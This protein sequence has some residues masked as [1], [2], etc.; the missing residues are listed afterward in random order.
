MPT[1]DI[2]CHPGLKT[3]IFNSDF[4]DDHP[5]FSTD[6]FPTD[7]RVDYPKMVQGGVDV[8]LSSVYIPE[9]PLISEVIKSSPLIHILSRFINVKEKAEFNSTPERPFEQT[10]E[11]INLFEKKIKRAADSGANIAVARSYDELER[12]MRDGKR[13]VIHSIEGAH[14]LGRKVDGREP[15]YISHLNVLFEKRVCLLTLAHFYKNDIVAPVI[16]MPPSVLHALDLSD[17]RDPDKGLSD[18]GKKVVEHM[19]KIGMVVD[20]AHCTKKARQ[21]VFAMNNSLGEKKRPLV[22]SHVGA[23]S[24]GSNGMNPDDNEIMRIKESGGVIG[25][26]FYNFYLSGKEEDN[27]FPF[28]KQEPGIKYIIDAVKHIREVTSG[29]DNIAI[30][31]DL[32]GF[33]DPSDDLFNTSCFQF[34]RERL[35]GAFG[36]EAAGKILGNNFMRVLKNGWGN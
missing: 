7:M 9:S 8:I 19:L 2:H 22:F 10:L 23:G 15:D 1:I 27:P 4:D 14:S 29:F 20:L 34:L 12:F 28:S 17:Y 3:W 13:A 35:T 30:G 24:F 31:S 6:F 33:T 16:G 36:E 11:F 25:L 5:S 26:I 18:A 32:D 21:E